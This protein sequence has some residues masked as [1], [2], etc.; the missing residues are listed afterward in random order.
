MNSNQNSRKTGFVLG[1]AR[2]GKSL[3]A[4]TLAKTQHTASGQL[5]YLATAQI[6]D[7]EMQARIDQHKQRRGPEWVLAEATVDLVDTLRRFEHP[8]NVILIDCLSVWMTNLIIGEH[9][10]AAHRDSLIAHLAISI[11]SLIFVASETGLGIVP[12]NALSRQFRDESGR[13]NQM[14]A[15]ASDDVFFVTAGIAQKIKP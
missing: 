1:G 3:H 13:L 12:D 9:D 15:R 5:V 2:S 11:S 4:E 8:D 14:V 7:E 10:I 6:F